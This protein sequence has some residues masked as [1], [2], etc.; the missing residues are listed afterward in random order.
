MHFFSEAHLVVSF[1]ALVLLA[2]V[3]VLT[4]GSKLGQDTPRIW[5]VVQLVV[6]IVIACLPLVNV[7]ALTAF[8]AVIGLHWI[9]GNY[10]PQTDC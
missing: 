9:E 2:I 8:A 5:R 7:L 3:A 4:I 1:L 10:F 6:A